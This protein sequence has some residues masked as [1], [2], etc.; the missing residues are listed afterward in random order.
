MATERMKKP[1]R[2]S[3]MSRL[4]VLALVRYEIQRAGSLR[5]YATHIGVSAA[6][7]S[8]VTRGRRNPGPA[9]LTPLKLRCVVTPPT[10]H[11]EQDDRHG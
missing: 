6:Y 3:V 9:I 10:H 5:K 11:Y 7:V 1:K 2:Y 4:E 8:D